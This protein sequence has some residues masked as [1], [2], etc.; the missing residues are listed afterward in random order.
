MSTTRN[1]I[2][3]LQSQQ[4]TPIS[5]SQTFSSFSSESL[6][7]PQRGLMRRIRIKNDEI[8]T[9]F[10]LN[11]NLF[12]QSKP[13][14]VCV[15]IEKL[16]HHLFGPYGVCVRKLCWLR[17]L[18]YPEHYKRKIDLTH[19]IQV[20]KLLYLEM[21]EH[22][23]NY[24]KRLDEAKKDWFRRSANFAY[25]DG[26][27]SSFVSKPFTTKQSS[28]SSTMMNTNNTN[29]SCGRSGTSG[30]VVKIF[31]RDH[32]QQQQRKDTLLLCNSNNNKMK[33]PSKLHLNLSL[34]HSNPK[35]GINND[36]SR[37]SKLTE[38]KEEDNVDSKD[39]TLNDFFMTELK[40]QTQPQT[41]V[42]TQP[43]TSLSCNNVFHSRKQL[44]KKLNATT[45]AINSK[46]VLLKQTNA[47]N[48]KN[49][50]RIFSK[51]NSPPS[52]RL[53]NFLS[54][55]ICKTRNMKNVIVLSQTESEIKKDLETVLDIKLHENPKATYRKIVQSM[56]RTKEAEYIK[57]IVNLSKS[58]SKFND[59]SVYKFSE[60]I[61]EDYYHKT[62]NNKYIR[63]E[64]CFRLRKKGKLPMKVLKV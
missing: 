29:H 57:T 6:C 47:E 34:V 1:V 35:H 26:Y 3:S 52:L 16:K 50:T 53:T 60:I 61:K 30:N 43:S 10:K 19:K 27:R 56:N 5:L 14:A 45:S 59:E 23:N 8:K 39:T 22:Q 12:K 44:Y 13:K 62:R 38:L 25:E 24:S 15:L 18:M 11:F 4:L 42:Q 17:N 51:G 64:N 32:Q 28:S 46:I 20:G 49:I 40:S 63:M 41:Q 7:K 48:K 31:S 2:P 36:E 54:N 33:L 9:L 58:V 21:K 55:K 37:N